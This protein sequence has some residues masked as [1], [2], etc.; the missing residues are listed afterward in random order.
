MSSQNFT[1]P[2]STPASPDKPKEYCGIFGVFNHPNASVLTYYGL[3]ALQHRGQEAAGIVTVSW[4]EEKKRNQMNAY[5][6]LG[7]VT[8]VF[9]NPKLWEDSLKGDMAIG[10][11][12]YSTSGSSNRIANIQP[13]Q[14][15]YKSGN[16]ALGH[17][18][19]LSNIREIRTRLIEEGTIFQSTTDSEVFLHLIAKS[20]EHD[21]V[22]QIRH[23]LLQVKGAYCLV[24]LTDDKLIAVRDPNGFRPLSLGKLGD[25]LVVASET[26]AF[27]IIGAEYIREV[28]HGEMLVIDKDEN[29]K[30]RQ[31]S[32][33]LPRP[34]NTSKCIFEFVYFSRPDSR[35]FGESVDKVRRKLGKNLAL[36]APVQ[37]TKEDKVFVISV[38]DSSNT[39][40]LGYV[41][42]SQKQGINARYELG[43]IRNHYVGRT[44]IHPEESGRGLKVRTKFNPVRGVIEGRKVV[45]VDDSIVR[46]TTSKNLMKLIRE[47]NPK[48]I[49]FRVSSPPIKHP[50]YYGLD[51][52]DPEKLIANEAGGD[53][54]KIAMEI[55]VDSLEYLSIEG[56]VSACGF[57]GDPL[58][59][60]F[61]TACFSGKY[62]VSIEEG[63]GKEEN[64]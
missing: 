52:P 34:A 54:K 39:A 4:D 9:R 13:F 22:A 29:G 21:Q 33:F 53:I 51:F 62:P 5:R 48:E 6:G 42:E 58:K 41:T 40:T 23:A 60:G 59:S 3:H 38:P 31:Q 35:I 8:D 12:R 56:M 18:G 64:D 2:S 28:E 43:L 17:N 49:H 27:D 1:E 7:L 19:N 63:I 57:D 25:A 24:I 36:E 11:N 44:F 16:I 50:C 61:C 26:C 32:Y 47:A 30:V 10:H 20:I 37:S 14:V 45:V 55:G 15:H 46:G